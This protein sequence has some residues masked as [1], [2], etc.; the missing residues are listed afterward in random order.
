MEHAVGLVAP[1]LGG[2]GLREKGQGFAGSSP[3]QCSFWAARGCRGAGIR[4]VGGAWAGRGFGV[5]GGGLG[6][7]EGSME[8]QG[9]QW[10]L[11]EGLVLRPGAVGCLGE[12]WGAP[13]WAKGDPPAPTIPDPCHLHPCPQVPVVPIVI[14]SY[15]D[16]YNKKEW[17]FTSGESWLGGEVHGHVG[18]G[19]WGAWAIWG[20]V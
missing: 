19:L 6:V 13:C 12:G 11:A 20:S 1:S 8:V 2:V 10:V 3:L 9:L 14:S 5:H 15:Q 18:R 4:E 17:R 7:V 16:F